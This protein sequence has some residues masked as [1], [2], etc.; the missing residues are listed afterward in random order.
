MQGLLRKFFGYDSK[1]MVDDSSLLSG[2]PVTTYR[3][4]NALVTHLFSA[5]L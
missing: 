3:L 4:K 1:G 5:I 2:F